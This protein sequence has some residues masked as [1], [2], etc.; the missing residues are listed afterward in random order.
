MPRY[1]LGKVDLK[2]ISERSGSWTAYGQGRTG[3]MK[4]FEADDPLTGKWTL[5][6]RSDYVRPEISVVAISYPKNRVF[7]AKA[8]KHT[9]LFKQCKDKKKFYSYVS[10]TQIDGRTTSRH[11][12]N[13]DE[14]MKVPKW[15]R[16]Y[17]DIRLY[18]NVVARGRN[19]PARNNLVAIIDQDETEDFALFFIATRIWPLREHYRATM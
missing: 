15:I 18:G 3:N 16:S 4:T 10:E 14:R 19:S 6:V 5:V 17:F 1:D 11:I 7:Y 2:L 13:K 12:F 9:I 8:A